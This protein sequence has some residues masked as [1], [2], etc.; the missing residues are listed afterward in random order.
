MGLNGSSKEFSQ[1]KS[2]VF[3]SQNNF[4]AIWLP[5]VL[6]SHRKCSI[7]YAFNECTW[8]F[9]DT[10][11]TIK[12]AFVGVTAVWE[13]VYF[14]RSNIIRI[15]WIWNCYKIPVWH[16]IQKTKRFYHNAIA[17]TLFFWH[18]HIHTHIHMCIQEEV[19]KKYITI[20]HLQL[21]FNLVF[22]KRLQCNTY[23]HI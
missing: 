2:K 3:G 5:F 12:A 15:I 20:I 22:T 10:I 9:F 17:G 19:R 1:R 4:A 8:P 14:I 11:N 16:N 7:S 23:T 21:C 6:L 18:T 13:M